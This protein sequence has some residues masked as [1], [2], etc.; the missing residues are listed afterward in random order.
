[1]RDLS[2]FLRLHA[3]PPL[4]RFSRTPRKPYLPLEV[5]YIIRPTGEVLLYVSN[6]LNRKTTTRIFPCSET[7]DKTGSKG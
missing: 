7:T 3:Y 5:R 1:M 6:A 4:A 2:F